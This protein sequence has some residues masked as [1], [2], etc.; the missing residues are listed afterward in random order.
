MQSTREPLSE[1]EY[2]CSLMPE[3]FLWL[4]RRF[5]CY[6]NLLSHT[7]ANVLRKCIESESFPTNFYSIE[8]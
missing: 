6:E 4:C 2:S 5:I 7:I 8:A 1:T 3:H